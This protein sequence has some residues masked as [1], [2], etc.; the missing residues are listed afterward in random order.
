MLTMI[1]SAGFD[2]ASIE[3]E[4]WNELPIPRSQLALPYREMPDEYLLPKTAP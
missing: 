2:V 1:H 4:R 3:V